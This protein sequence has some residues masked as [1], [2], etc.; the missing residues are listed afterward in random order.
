MPPP[1][2]KLATAAARD[3]QSIKY[4]FF[5]DCEPLLGAVVLNGE[6]NAEE[7]SSKSGGGLIGTGFVAAGGCGDEAAAAGDG[8]GTS[9]KK[10]LSCGGSLRCGLS[11]G[12]GGADVVVAPAAAAA[13]AERNPQRVLSSWL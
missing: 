4:N 13:A 7:P 9:A 10:L 11:G 3:R 8:E 5:P 1:F 6:S 12:E 2:A